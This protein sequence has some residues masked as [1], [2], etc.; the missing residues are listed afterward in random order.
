MSKVQFAVDQRLQGRSSWLKVVRDLN[1]EQEPKA[2]RGKGGA[3]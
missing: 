1:P 2:A 3:A